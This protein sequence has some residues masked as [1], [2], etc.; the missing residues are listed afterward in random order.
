MIA[1]VL[2]YFCLLQL[3]LSRRRIFLFAYLL[4]RPV[5]EILCSFLV[6]SCCIFI[7]PTVLA[8]RDHVPSTGSVFVVAVS[9]FHAV[10]IS[11]KSLD[12]TWR[13]LTV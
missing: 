6:S 2:K 12:R 1:C 5:P 13:L 8:L 9:A 7:I 4:P 10:F 3:S 11:I